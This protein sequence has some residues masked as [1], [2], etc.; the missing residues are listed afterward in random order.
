MSDHEEDRH[1]DVVEKVLVS[2]ISYI[3]MIYID[4]Y[5]LIFPGEKRS[6]NAVY[7]CIS[8]TLNQSVKR[9]QDDEKE[10]QTS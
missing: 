2:H 9:E 1:T 5:N 4:A 10:K 3:K 6:S 8:P 7:G